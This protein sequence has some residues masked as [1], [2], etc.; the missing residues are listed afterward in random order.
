M[1]SLRNH[2]QRLV[3]IIDDFRGCPVAVYGDLVADEFLFGE[4]SRVSREAPVLILRYRESQLLPGGAANAVNNLH[5]LGAAP[6]P[7]GVLGKDPSGVELWRQFR[8]KKICLDYVERLTGYRTPTKTR[9]LAGS[10]HSSRQQVLRLDREDHFIQT[11]EIHDSLCRRIRAALRSCRGIVVSDYGFGFVTPEIAGLLNRDRQ[12]KPVVLDSRYR[13]LDYFGLTA[14]TPNEPEVEAA[15]GIQIG[16]NLEKLE[17]A[18]RVLL[19]RLGLQSILITRGRHGM[20]LF[21]TRQRTRHI[22]IYGTDEIADVTGAG[23]TVISVY[24][25]ALSV[26]AS[27]EEAAFLSNCAGGIVVMKRGTATVSAV[28][29]KEAVRA[30]RP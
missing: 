3:R 7:V 25:L 1:T 22:P 19:K 4:I 18:G 28:E 6:V 14:A 15:L 13:L 17:Q 27:F 24:T 23:D 30:Y 12:K 9:F 10:V 20:A 11:Q 5:A 16:N 29:L 2:Q 21:V 26:G 8:A